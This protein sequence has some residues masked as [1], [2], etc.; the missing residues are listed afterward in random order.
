[1]NIL[2]PVDGN[3]GLF[4][5]GTGQIYNLKDFKPYELSGLLGGVDRAFEIPPTERFVLFYWYISGERHP[6]NRSSLQQIVELEVEGE[7]QASASVLSVFVDMQN[8]PA[9]SRHMKPNYGMELRKVLWSQL[10]KPTAAVQIKVRL[11]EQPLEG[12]G[13]RV[14]LVGSLRPAL[15]Y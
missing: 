12:C 7:I 4:R 3:P 15:T 6:T 11:R 8:P 5:D 1:M 2:V 14:H 9:A 10:S 13:A